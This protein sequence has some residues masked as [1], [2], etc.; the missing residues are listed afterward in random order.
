MDTPAL[1]VEHLGVGYKHGGSVLHDVSLSVTEG[2]LCVVTGPSGCGKSTLLH[3]LSGIVKGYDGRVLIHGRAP[4]PKVQ[5]IGLVPQ[6]YG[7]LPW[8]RVR[9]NILLP[10]ALDKT[11]ISEAELQEITAELELKELL[12]RYPH[13][14][15]GGQ[16]QRVAIA[17]AF[18][19]EPELL[20]L[21]EPFSALD[22]TTAEKCRQLFQRVRQ[23][24]GVT[25]IMVTHNIDEAVAM[26]DRIV[27]IG[28]RPGRVLLDDRN[29]DAAV[30]KSLLNGIES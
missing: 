24:T 8:K 1:L 22:M 26:G 4:N 30:V 6:N 5:S 17:R 14:L 19:Q 29:R 13:E 12:R 15:S 2:E 21:D 3:V 10:S 18:A 28:G 23:K 27:L 16:R 20:L 7:L 11:R 9:D 25:T